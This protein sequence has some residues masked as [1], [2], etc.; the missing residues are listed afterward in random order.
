MLGGKES[1]A[2]GSYARTPVGD[3]LPV[4]LE[5]D[6]ASVPRDEYRLKLTREGWLQPWVRLRANEQDETKR[7]ATMPVFKT[8]NRIDSIKPGAS[9]LA[10]MEDGAGGLR[11]ALV[12]QPFG[13]G[14][15]AAIT[16]ADLWRWQLKRDDPKENDLD[17]A[18]R[19]T[20]RWLV[21]DVPKPVEVETRRAG[22]GQGV[23][24]VVRCRDKQFEPLDNS[25]VKLKV[26]TPD[27]REI[28]IVAEASD[29]GPGLY[30][31][32]FAPRVAGAY[33]ATV[34]VSAADGSPV[35]ER[36]TGWSV[37]P[38]TEEF[39]TLAVNRPLLERIAT[40]SGGEVLSL[41]ELDTFV[42]SLPNRKIPQTETWTYPLWHQWQV[43]SLALACLIGEWGLRRWRGLP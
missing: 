7:L 40:E 30:Q 15:V 25:E 32:S 33:R 12:V 24:I 1:F 5:R 37:E 4:Y 38:E 9:V 34:S 19:Q 39:R 17:K 13:R 27:K 16:I 23:E 42:A 14:R 41:D 20:V 31:A 18:W 43:F 36:E 35:G 8:A 28:D 26:H 11:P 6:L 22:G 3:M 10:E 29:A 21:A 2:E